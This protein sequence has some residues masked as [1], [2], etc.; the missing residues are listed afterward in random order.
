MALTF[1]NAEKRIHDMVLF[2]AFDL[3]VE[4][5]KATAIYSSVNVREHLISLLL[6]RSKLSNG[7][8]IKNTTEIGFLFLEHG[9]YERLRVKEMLA[10]TKKLYA[11]KVSVEEALQTLQLETIQHTPIK[12]L[13]HSETRRV[14]LA[15]LHIQDPVLYILEEPEQN[16]DLESKR[17]YVAF[18]DRLRKSNKAVLVMT[19]NLESVVAVADEVYKLGSQGLQR[20]DIEE[21]EEAEYSVNETQHVQ[22]VQFEKIPTKVD[23]KIVL[24]N[25]PEIDYIESVEGQSYLHIAGESFLCVFTLAELEEKLN[26]FGFFR[27]HRSYI[28]NLQ[29]VKEV[30]SWTRNSYSLVLEPSSHS[31]IPLSKSKMTEL[32]EILGL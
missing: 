26:P 6:G 29:K 4:S 30:I 20:M 15:C 5:G 8:M 32:K 3:N 1:Q 25:P 12:R 23:E 28:V 7:K 22:P 24:F 13:T 2:P 11:S 9:L 14:Q 17:I 16:V 31:T 19:G 10:F 27:C 18:L 21:E